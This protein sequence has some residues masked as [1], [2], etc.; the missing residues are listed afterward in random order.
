MELHATL[1]PMLPPGRYLLSW[2]MVQE[3]VL[4][5]SS[6]GV[7]EG[8]TEVAILQGDT[9]APPLPDSRRRHPGEITAS[10]PAI[11][12]RAVLWQAAVRMWI[13]RPL[14]GHGPNNFRHLYG[15]YI[16]QSEW[17]ARIHANNLYLE[18]LAD[19]GLLGAL[20]FAWL[21]FAIGQRLGPQIFQSEVVGRRLWAA[22]LG[23]AFLAFL[24]HGF[25]D[26]FFE[27][28]AISLL[29]WTLTGLAGALTRYKVNSPSLPTSSSPGPSL[30][31][32]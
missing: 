30:N 7:P 8:L 13:D 4:P 25:L 32:R 9:P 5:F 24:V 6:R 19:N 20:A 29:F 23:A 31:Q 3:G 18:L 17:D 1:E 27:F 14:L 22:G 12:S 21:L 2:G 26:Y 28:H 16:G 10:P 11:T 15:P